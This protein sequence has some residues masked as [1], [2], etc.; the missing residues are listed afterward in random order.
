M[1]EYNGALVIYINGAP[2]GIISTDVADNVYGFVELQGDCERICITRNRK[3]KQ[4][5]NMYIR[6]HA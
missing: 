1:P 4:V 6:M 2:L 5:G 3:I